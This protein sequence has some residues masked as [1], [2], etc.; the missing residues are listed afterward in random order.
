[1]TIRQSAVAGM[2]Y[3][4]NPREIRAFLD[5][6]MA[7]ATAPV[8]AC[9]VVVPHAGWIYSGQLAAQVLARVRVPDTVV[10]IGPNHT[11]L[12][13]AISIFPPGLWRTPVGDIP[14]SPHARTLAARLGLTCDTA[15]H[16]REHSLEVLLPMLHY[17][18][19]SL[20]IIAIT[21][22]GGSPE[23]A[24]ELAHTLEAEF[25]GEDVL[26]LASSDMNHFES[27]AVSDRKNA[28]AMERIA[29]LDSPGLLE[30]VNR[31][32]IS[33]CGA[34]PVAVALE[35]ALLRG[36]SHA[37]LVGYTDS[38]AV[39][40]DHDSVVGYAGYILA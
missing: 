27:Q 16:Q 38:A 5:H 8:D 37:S 31:H 29:A 25:Q 3:P 39:S 33:M 13:S 23:D 26:L 34:F 21:V 14:V 35:N 24:R 6:H 28:L 4:D 20:Q 12:G 2:F 32:R 10:I 30:V 22:A 11:G 40:G 9:A 19:P 1:M 36:A 15:A 17:R 7:A 18:N